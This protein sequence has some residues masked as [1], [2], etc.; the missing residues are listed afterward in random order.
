MP[1]ETRE[2]NKIRDKGSGKTLGRE[3]EKRQEERKEGEQEK[4]KWREEKIIAIGKAHAFLK[5][6]AD[7]HEA[8]YLHHQ[9]YPSNG[10][11]DFLR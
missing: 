9:F 11:Y 4:R 2:I 7:T 6:A 1:V 5:A 3:R 8:H 10:R